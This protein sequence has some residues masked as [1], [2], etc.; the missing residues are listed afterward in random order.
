MVKQAETGTDVRWE[1][2]LKQWEGPFS[3][4]K[5]GPPQAPDVAAQHRA[6]RK[7]FAG[8]SARPRGRE[9][10]GRLSLSG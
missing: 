5:E 2:P 4:P 7:P 9:V 6:A 8:A 3:D 10:G 1:P